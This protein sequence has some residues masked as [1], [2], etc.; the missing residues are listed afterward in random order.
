[1][2]AL[3]PLPSGVRRFFRTPEEDQALLQFFEDDQFATTVS[4]AAHFGC[5][6]V[7][8]KKTLRRLREDAKQKAQDVTPGP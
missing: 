6:V 2:R 1:M 4:A 5:S 8:V 3:R 7:L